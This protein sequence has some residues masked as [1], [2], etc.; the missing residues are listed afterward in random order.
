MK[1][2]GFWNF[3][4][5]SS[6]FRDRKVA[7]PLKHGRLAGPVCSGLP[8]RDRKVAA[9]LKRARRPRRE[10]VGRPFRDRKVAAPLKPLGGS[11]AGPD[12][13]G[14]LPRPKGRG[15]IEAELP[16][17][18][19]TCLGSLPRPKGRGP[20]EAGAPGPFPV[21]G[22]YLPRP[23]GRGPIEAHPVK[24]PS[25]TECVPSATERSRPH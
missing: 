9:P 19:Q 3:T 18:G 15:P 7:A 1:P 20:I 12:D 14:R 16:L 24:T 10:H 21:Y 17:S 13:A 11:G 2:G 23:K 6:A 4:R 22:T 25:S 5:P 8:F